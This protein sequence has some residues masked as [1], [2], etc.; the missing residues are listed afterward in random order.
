[1]QQDPH[2]LNGLNVHEGMLTYQA[3]AQAQSLDFV[4]PES[5]I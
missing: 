2:L 3:V 5:L 4:A 1:M